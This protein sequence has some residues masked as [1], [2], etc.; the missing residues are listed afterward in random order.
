MRIPLYFVVYMFSNKIKYMCSVNYNSSFK[1]NPF[2][3][4]ATAVFCDVAYIA[5]ILASDISC[6]TFEG[7]VSSGYGSNE[8]K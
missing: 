1:F 4:A 5:A 2:C 8:S 6:C 7:G 3:I